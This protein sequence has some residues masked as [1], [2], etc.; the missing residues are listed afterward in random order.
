M[1]LKINM[2]AVAATKPKV[3]IAGVSYLP[4]ESEALH[5]WPED[6]VRMGFMD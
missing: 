4:E 1:S 5:S 6:H 3:Q 2:E